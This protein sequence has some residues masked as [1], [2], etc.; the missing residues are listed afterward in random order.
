MEFYFLYLL[1][2]I[3]AGL[4]AGMFGIGGGGYI[5]PLLVTVFA[6]QGRLPSQDVMH[7]ALA[8]TMISILFAALSSM[9]AHHQRGGVNWSIFKRMSPFMII[10]TFTGIFVVS[11]L[12]SL[13]L[14]IFFALFILF[15]SYQMYFDHL[16]RVSKN[17][18]SLRELLI[19]G[20]VI[21]FIS[22][23]V[24]IGGGS[25]T[26]PYLKSRAI[27]LRTAIGT[28]AA[29]GFCIALAGSFG[30]LIQGFYH[31]SQQG[32][33]G[34]INTRVALVIAVSSYFTAPLGA[35]LAYQ[36]PVN[37]LRKL[38]AILLL[39]LSLKMMWTIV[40]V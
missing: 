2:G 11:H 32:C 24:S 9:R 3:S 12:S 6:I 8:T 21:G 25:L 14:S 16:I 18:P 22:S 7:F 20:L 13:Y 39:L 30:Y 23:L 4:F 17:S 37:V 26:V 35:R 34:F 19:V 38:F 1:I 33:W 40:A 29:L 5:V 10:G 27:E 31:P 28:S 36:L 15:I